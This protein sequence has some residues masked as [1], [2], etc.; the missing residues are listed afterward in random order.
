MH[1]AVW[2]DASWACASDCVCLGLG[3]KTQSSQPTFCA[4][5]PGAEK[6]HLLRA[7]CTVQDTYDFTSEQQEEVVFRPL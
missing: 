4:R 6:R 3:T 5:R 7:V 1:Y 2:I